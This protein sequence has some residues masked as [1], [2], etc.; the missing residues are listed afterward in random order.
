MRFG[1]ILDSPVKFVTPLVYTATLLLAA[2]LVL[3]VIL[4]IVYMSLLPGV[5]FYLAPIL[6]LSI[7]CG[8]ASWGLLW[9]EGLQRPRVID[10]LRRCA[11]LYAGS[12]F[13]G[14][15]WLSA[16]YRGAADG[17]HAVEIVALFCT[18]TLSY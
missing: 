18:S 1:E 15:L 2:F 7:V 13:W 11:L 4:P 14:F 9:L 10:H 17:G 6:L 16:P 3:Q 12:L 5:W 8:S